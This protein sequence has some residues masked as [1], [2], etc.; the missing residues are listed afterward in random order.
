MITFHVRPAERVEEDDLIHTIEELR[1][2]VRTQGFEDLLAYRDVEIAARP[3]GMLGDELAAQVGRHDRHGVLEV[4]RTTLP[5]GQPPL[6]EQLQEDI[7]HLR[8]GLLDLVEEHDR[9]RT[10]ADRFGELPGLF[11]PD[12]AGRRADQARGGVLLLVLRHVD[13][14][15]SPGPGRTGIRRAPGRARSCQLPWVQER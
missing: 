1:S 10:P 15:S 13:P 9:I 11:V 14:D 7:E 5:V 2:E 4:D 12:V 6:I 3:G 8:M